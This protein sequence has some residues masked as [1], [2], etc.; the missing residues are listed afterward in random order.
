MKYL[1][2]LTAILIMVI[3][4]TACVKTAPV[5]DVVSL[6]NIETPP[7]PDGSFVVGGPQIVEITVKNTGHDPIEY[8]SAAITIPV[9]ASDD[10]FDYNA[11][12]DISSVNPLKPG[13]STTGTFNIAGVTTVQKYATYPL[14]LRVT[15]KNKTLDYTEQVMIA[16]PPPAK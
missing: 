1:V 3:G 11:T 2:I 6:N 12:F 14:K 4:L 10:K 7:A 15:L 13:E 8:I 5:I 9:I 16:T